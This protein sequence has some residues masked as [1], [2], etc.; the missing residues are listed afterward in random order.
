MRWHANVK[1]LTAVLP[2]AAMLVFG[3]AEIFP[4]RGADNQAVPF[5][6]GYRHWTFLHSSLIS[7]TLAGFWKRPCDKPCTAGIFHFYAN[8]KAM[9][10][11]RSG[12]YADGAI[13]AEEM[14]EFQGSA[15]GGGKEGGLR[16]VGVMVKDNTR[17]ASTGGWGFGSYDAPSHED[18]LDSGA[19]TACFACHIPRKDRGF[20][21]TE[22]RER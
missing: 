8:D 1:L 18:Q 21:F 9:A 2:A 19:K 11:L 3:L 4:A 10:G 13:I 22:Y 5:P 12:E 7:P 20:V 16:L 6:D 15:S 14:L 17:Y